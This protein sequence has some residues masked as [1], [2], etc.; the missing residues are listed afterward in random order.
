MHKST[1]QWV[2]GLPSNQFLLAGVSC[3][4]LGFSGPASAA[5]ADLPSIPSDWRLQP[6][7][8]PTISVGLL[9]EAY[10]IHESPK[11]IARWRDKHM[12]DCQRIDITD[13][14]DSSYVD[15]HDRHCIGPDI[16]VSLLQRNPYFIWSIARPNRG[17]AAHPLTTQMLKH[18]A[19][20]LAAHSNQFEQVLS[21][22]TARSLWALQ[23]DAQQYFSAQGAELIETQRDPNGFVQTWQLG[24][25]RT[26]IVASRTDT[27]LTILTA[28]EGTAL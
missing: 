12:P 27:G 8:A 16:I 22:T 6:L 10:T 17:L 9:I 19:T 7:A 4:L 28:T 21:V 11:Q 13:T 26:H 20:L 25:V 14:A 2:S 18:G 23:H 15:V 24:P 3:C 1:L 5:P